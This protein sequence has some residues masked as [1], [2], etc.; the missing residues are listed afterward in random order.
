[1]A[2]NPVSRPYTG[3]AGGWGSAQSLGEIL[4][5]QGVPLSG[6]VILTRQNKTRGFACV[7]CAWAKPA[8]PHPFEF[9]ENGAKATAWEI[10]SAR[11]RPDFFA[12]HRVAELL[13]W[14]DLELEK[15]GRLTDPMRWDAATDTYRT[16][17][18]SD[19]FNE[20][21]AE[22]RRFQADQAVF[23]A[24]GRASLETSYMY[25]L[26]ARLYGTNNLPDSSNMCHETTS[27]ALPESIGF[28]VGTVVL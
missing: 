3:P 24:S 16:V 6:A 2:R 10:T 14:S 4:V 25:A 12:K 5:E 20:I 13:S 23:Y 27:V 7:S 19:A 17:A 11:T 26:M 18:W 28:S 21:G 22:L 9:C 1:M 8:T 15:Q